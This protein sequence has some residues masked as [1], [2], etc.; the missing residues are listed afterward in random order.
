MTPAGTPAAALREAAARF[1]TPVHVVSAMT[2]A[3]GSEELRAA[4]PDPWLRA[5]SVKA[6]DVPG[7]IA[8]LA[9]LGVDGNVV[10]RGEWAT[11]VAGGLPNGRITL[12]GIGKTQGDL[13]SAVRAAAAGSPL[14][15]VAVESPEELDELVGLAG[16]A[17]RPAAAQP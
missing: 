16:R 13:R 3:A 12:E 5:F 6:N 15:W 8:R 2:L 10:S 9:G 7:V 17:G 11:A 4:F 14:R 1:G